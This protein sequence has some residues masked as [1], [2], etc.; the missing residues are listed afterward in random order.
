M[1]LPTGAAPLPIFVEIAA[2]RDGTACG[3]LRTMTRD[4]HEF[5]GEKV[6][7]ERPMVAASPHGENGCGLRNARK[8]DRPPTFV[9]GA[10]NCLLEERQHG[11]TD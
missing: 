11:V 8:C 1:R 7:G 4:F 3:E 9:T 2:R 6:A 10:L 5:D